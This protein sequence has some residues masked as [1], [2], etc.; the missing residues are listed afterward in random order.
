M[1]VDDELA[2]EVEES[3]EVVPLA[4]VL[5]EER[6]EEV[7]L[8]EALLADELAA[9]EAA[10]VVVIC[11]KREVGEVRVSEALSW[12]SHVRTPAA[13]PGRL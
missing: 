2:V 12:L 6:P 4:E 13:P 5:A 11:E 9:E 7:L 8:S 1:A 10:E 3:A